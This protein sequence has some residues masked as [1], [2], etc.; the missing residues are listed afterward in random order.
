MN[1]PLRL[2]KGYAS[3]VKYAFIMPVFFFFFCFVYDPFSFRV[4]YGNV[5]GKDSSF[6]LIM[7]SCIMVGVFALSR[8]VFTFLYKYIPFKRWHYLAWCLGEVIVVS[9]FFAMYTSLFYKNSGTMPYFAALPKCFKIV[10]L[11]L[12]YPYVGGILLRVIEN[13]SD[14]MEK[15]AD[16]PEESRAKFYDEHRRLKLT[17]D[18][19]VI[20][21]VSADAN[22]VNIHYLENDRLKAYQLRNSMKSLEAVARKHGLVRCH[23][24]YYVNP[25][26]V[27]V[28]SRDKDGIIY[29][30]FTHEGV[31][32]IPVSKMYY[33]DLANLL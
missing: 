25:R 21:Y 6:H 33:D 27:K 8:L 30:E 5:G 26:H 32:R 3:Q 2:S 9:L 20:L 16:T 23:R 1:N 31:G 19:S 4:L 24:S 14:D 29:T 12:V 22:Y 10:S 15:M 17:I 13:Q 7:L 18:P 11:T 28:L